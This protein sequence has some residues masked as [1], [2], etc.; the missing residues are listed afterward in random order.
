MPRTAREVPWLEVRGGIYYVNWYKPP[1]DP[2][3]K[4]RTER[5]S[6]RTRDPAEATTRLAAFLVN[7]EAV[8]APKNVNNALG[9]AHALQQYFDEHV[10]TSVTDVVRQENA[11]RHLKAYF[12]NDPISSIDIPACRGYAAARRSGAI[13]GGARHFGERAKGSD[14]T[15]RR[16]LNVLQA[17][18]RHALRWKRITADRMPT[19]ELPAEDEVDE[20]VM[21]LSKA[22]VRRLIRKA[23]GELRLFVMLAYWT[24]SRRAAIETLR[25]DQINLEQNRINLSKPGERKTKKRRPIVPLF[26]RL[27]PF[28]RRA[29]AAAK[30]EGRETLFRPG[31]DFYKPFAA[32]CRAEGL[33]ERDFPHILR[34]SRATHMLMDGESI[35]K[36]G[37]LL[38]D[39]VKTIENRYGHSSVEF[40]EGRK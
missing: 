4:G 34:H 18:A 16:E 28:V 39:T 27:R 14:S 24:G 26:W 8:F 33:G 1:A 3:G 19:F 11:I 29:V 32:L 40:L 36:V 35:Y 13:G 6:L 22:E 5:F 10:K 21:W 15:I 17:A 30:A 37:R 7:G 23:E 12:G 20:E 25:L 38:G 31:I 9:T 2:K